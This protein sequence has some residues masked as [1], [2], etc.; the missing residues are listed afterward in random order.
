VTFSPP[1]YRPPKAPEWATYIEDRR[2][3]FKVHN[4]RGQALNAVRLVLAKGMRG[5][6]VYRLIDGTWAEYDRVTPGAPTLRRTAR[7]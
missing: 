2:P 7:Y 5:G 6:I 4:G 1:D 3:Q